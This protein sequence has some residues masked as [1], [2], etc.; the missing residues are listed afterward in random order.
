[1][2]SFP[3]MTYSKGKPDIQ[4]GDFDPDSKRVPMGDI[5]VSVEK[6][7]EQADRFG[8]S[9]ERELAFLSVHGMLHLLGYDHESPEEEKDM[10]QR[11][12][13]VLEELGLPR[14]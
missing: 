7:L 3:L 12:E 13:E 1:M 2:L 6:A 5:M 8:H 10:I 4:P 14:A 11:Q 9:F